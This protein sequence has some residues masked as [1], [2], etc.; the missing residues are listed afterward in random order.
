MIKVSNL[1][2]SAALD[3]SASLKNYEL[4]EGEVFDFS[5]VKNSDPFPMLLASAAI[6]QLRTRSTVKKCKAENCDNSYAEHMRFYKAIGINVGHEL[7]E[8]YGNGNYLPITRLDM[9]DLRDSGIRNLERIQEVIAKKSRDMATVLSRG[10]VSFA[11]WLTY[12]LTEI[13]RNIPEHSNADAIWY[14]TQYWPSYDLVELAILDEG[15]GVRESLLSNG[16]Y[17]DLVNTDEDALR[18]ALEPGISRTFVPGGENLSNDEWKNSGFGLYMVSRLCD[19][20]GGS[21]I[22]ASGDS[23]LRLCND[24][25][26][27]SRCYLEGTGIQ[28]RISPSQIFKYKD[29]ARDILNEGETKV[30]GNNK[31]F[32]AASKSTKSLFSFQE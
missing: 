27:F 12:V 24:R 26:Q 28:I 21:F 4:E 7:N 32:S 3:F 1:T 25:Y 15:Q 18:L 2:F 23:A 29:V 8:N 13:M 22:I 5:A 16:A 11:N 10:N 9:K 20:L 17:D 31:A 14:C 30:K 19:R 6:R